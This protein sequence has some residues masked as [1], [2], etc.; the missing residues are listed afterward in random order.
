VFS[1]IISLTISGNDGVNDCIVHARFKVVLT[2][3][4]VEYSL[5]LIYFT[6]KKYQ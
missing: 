5:L 4:L 6:L 1:P 2:S 3:T